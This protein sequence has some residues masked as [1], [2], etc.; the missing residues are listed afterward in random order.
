MVPRKVVLLVDRREELEDT[1]TVVAFRSC[2]CEATIQRW[3]SHQLFGEDFVV[4][5]GEVVLLIDLRKDF[6]DTV[7]VVAFRSASH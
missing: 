1:K 6:E 5:L 3:N 4:V 2:S 7:T